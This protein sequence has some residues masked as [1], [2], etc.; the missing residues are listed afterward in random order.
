MPPFLSMQ[1]GVVHETFFTRKCAPEIAKCFWVFCVYPITA[2]AWNKS[3]NRL[4]K[5]SESYHGDFL[6][7]IHLSV[8]WLEIRFISNSGLILNGLQAL[9]WHLTSFFDHSIN[10]PVQC[11]C[12]WL[13]QWYGWQGAAEGSCVGC[14]L[15]AFLVGAKDSFQPSSTQCKGRHQVPPGHGSRSDNGAKRR[16][17]ALL[18]QSCA[19]LSDMDPK[20]PWSW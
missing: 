7:F 15:Q 13:D 2:F 8:V 6:E 17:I 5:I 14:P 19:G 18:L 3:E 12:R 20:Y 1:S 16:F 4:N 9:T 10:L 11:W